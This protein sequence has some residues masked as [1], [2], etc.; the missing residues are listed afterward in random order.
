MPSPI[1]RELSFCPRLAYSLPTRPARESIESY[2]LNA[3]ATTDTV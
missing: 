1:G 3:N 2:E